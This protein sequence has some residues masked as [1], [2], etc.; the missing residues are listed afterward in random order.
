MSVSLFRIV[1]DRDDIIIGLTGTELDTMGGND[2]PT[3]ART[4]LE[5]GTLPAWQYAV[6]RQDGALV[7][8]PRMRVALLAHGSLRVEPYGSAFPVLAPPAP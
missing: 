5:K 6:G 8:A 2:A 4:L 1:S 7:H 3:L